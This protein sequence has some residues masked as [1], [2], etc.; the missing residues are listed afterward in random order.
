[1][2][3]TPTKARA[4]VREAPAGP[5]PGET[6]EGPTL[7]PGIGIPADESPL[8]HLRQVVERLAPTWGPRRPLILTHRTPDPDALG[9]MFGLDVLL[10]QALGLNP[11][12]AATGRISR[13]ENVAMVEELCLDYVDSTSLDRDKY[14]AVFLV[15]TQPGFGHTP[16]P[17]GIP[18]VAVFDH[19]RP[20]DMEFL[21]GRELPPHYDLRLEAGATSALM[22]GYLQEAGIELDRRTATVL[23]CGIRFDT[24]DLSTS[25]TPLDKEA[26]YETF[27]RSDHK[28]LAR[29]QRPSLPQI[30]YHDLYRSLSRARLYGSTVLGFLGRVQNPESVAEMADFFR[31]LNGCTWSLVG[32][33]VGETY[34]LSLRTDGAEAYPLLQHVLGKEGSFGGR[35]TVAGG[36]VPLET[37]EWSELQRLER[38]LR[39]RARELLDPESRKTSRGL[40]LTQGP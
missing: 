18:V 33:A 7:P 22:Y 40:R 32:G 5:R 4:A 11:E 31:R 20:P 16:L 34:H 30:Y 38:R 25:A 21:E 8:E 36:Q 24:L 28:I 15:D 17:E 14:S 12:L 23:C 2:T 39:K 6:P 10:R 1:M 3:P 35:G 29:I 37:G 26:F 13:A 19:H 9:A 27:R